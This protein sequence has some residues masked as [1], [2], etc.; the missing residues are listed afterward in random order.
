MSGARSRQEDA[1]TERT[2]AP[3]V[4]VYDGRSCI[5][6]VLARGRAGYEAFG[7]DETS[8]GLF[9]TQIAAIDTI[10]GSTS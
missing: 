8:L 3:L 10:S 4:T 5:G 9:P 6:F 7:A 2:A 1:R